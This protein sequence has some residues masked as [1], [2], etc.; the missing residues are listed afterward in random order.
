MT[1]VMPRFETFL[2]GFFIKLGAWN[3]RRIHKRLGSVAEILEAAT[4]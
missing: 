3:A 4:G 1:E 2:A